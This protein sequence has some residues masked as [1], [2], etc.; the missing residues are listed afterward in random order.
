MQKKARHCSA[1][2]DFVFRNAIFCF[3]EKCYIRTQL[4]KDW[5]ILTNLGQ[6]NVPSDICI[7]GEIKALLKLPPLKECPVLK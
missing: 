2:L 6:F 4:D 5:S 1:Q 7:P 3:M